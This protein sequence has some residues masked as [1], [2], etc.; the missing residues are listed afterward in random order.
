MIQTAVVLAG[1]L[2]LVATSGAALADGIQ[3]NGGDNRLIG[4][5]DKDNISGDDDISGKG[6]R[7]RLFGDARADD[8][9]GG[10]GGDR[11]QGGLAGDDLFGQTG[12]DFVNAIDGQTNDFVDCGEGEFDI[13]GIDGFFGGSDR[14][15]NRYT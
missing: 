11:I 10:N 4:T 3:G 9:H 14:D 6:N 7:D 12:N 2:A 8:V 5:N 15:G 13:A 1:V